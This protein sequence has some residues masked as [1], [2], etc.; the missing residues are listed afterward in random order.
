VEIDRDKAI[1]L[2]LITIATI[3]ALAVMSFI[4]QFIQTVLPFVIVAAGVF[5]GYKWV[6]S[7]TAAPTAD[8]VEEQ[9][10]GLFS[11]FRKSKDAV[12]KTM[13]VGAVISDLQEKFDGKDEDV[14]K[15]EVVTK[16]E[17]VEPVAEAQVVAEEEV[18]DDTDETEQVLNEIKQSVES[19]PE[20]QIEFKDGDVV[21]SKDDLVQPDTSRLEEKAKEEPKVTDNV[22]S[23]IEERRRRLEEGRNS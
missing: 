14:V 21:I 6:L 10:R 18:E 12:E 19:D 11:R 23:Q 20:G 2:V 15:G 4:V 22:L 5:A 16:A 8:E 3:A 1:K 9:A 17:T 7:D 13:K